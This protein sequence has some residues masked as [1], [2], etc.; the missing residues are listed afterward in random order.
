MTFAVRVV[1][2]SQ[3]DESIASVKRI[4][5]QCLE[6]LLLPLQDRDAEEAYR[7]DYGARGMG[8]ELGTDAMECF[9]QQEHVWE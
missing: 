7:Y 1:L 5:E 2:L 4:T 3:F 6:N 9:Q 8:P